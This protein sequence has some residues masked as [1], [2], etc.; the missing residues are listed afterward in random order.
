MQNVIEE[1]IALQRAYSDQN[2]PEMERRGVLIRDVL[3]TELR[4]GRERLRAAL[5]PYGEDADAEGRDGTGRKTR[6]PWVRWFSRSRS[7][8]A[9]EGWYVVYLFHPEGAGVS[10]CP[11]WLHG[12]P[13]R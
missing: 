3:P 10:L 7:P 4:R 1:V 5:G 12:A 13:K 8:S 6:I 9:Q 2:T 11:P